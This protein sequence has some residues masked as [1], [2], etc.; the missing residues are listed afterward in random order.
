METHYTSKLDILD[1]AL[2]AAGLICVII[3]LSYWLGELHFTTATILFLIAGIALFLLAYWRLSN[4]FHDINT[5]ESR[6]C[7]ELTDQGYEYTKHDGTLYVK[8]SD[9]SFHIHLWDTS[10][11]RIKRLYIV[12]DFEDERRKE[13]TKEG[14]AMATNRINTDNPHV[15]FITY[16]KLYR[17][18]Y[19]TAICNAK[20]FLPEFETAYQIIGEAVE[21]HKNIIP[22]LEMDY[23]NSD[24][25]KKS[26]IGFK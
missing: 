3:P 6:I 12:Y 15:T 23:P 19:E 17:C 20:D 5:I 4:A 10:N 22:Y 2:F 13:I 7:N 14:W 11:K 18:R 21:E 25:N 24:S 9:T 1:I 8:K 26:N 16:N